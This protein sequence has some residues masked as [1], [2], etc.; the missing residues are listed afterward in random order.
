M[1][2]GLKC[3]INPACFLLLSLLEAFLSYVYL[4]SSFFKVL[5]PFHLDL[6][7]FKESSFIL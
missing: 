1:L 3:F 4:K 2:P 6:F 5:W 7:V